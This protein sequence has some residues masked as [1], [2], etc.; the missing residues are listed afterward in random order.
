MATAAVGSADTAIVASAFQNGVW[1][2][3][4]PTTFKREDLAA[5]LNRYDIDFADVRGQEYAKRAMVVSASG[6]HNLL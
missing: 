1:L 6:S 5:Q 3:I 2:P 4:V